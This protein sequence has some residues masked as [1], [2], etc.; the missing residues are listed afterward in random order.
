MFHNN[1]IVIVIIYN[2]AIKRSKIK[3]DTIQAMLDTIC[4]IGMYFSRVNNINEHCESLTA[5]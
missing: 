4:I 1:N 3:Y 5:R 2:V